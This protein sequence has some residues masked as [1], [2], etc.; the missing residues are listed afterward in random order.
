MNI[1]GNSD[2]RALVVIGFNMQTY[3]INTVLLSHGL[4]NDGF[5]IL[6]VGTA[7]V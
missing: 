6:G 1:A 5:P 4:A 3:P 7:N 2:A